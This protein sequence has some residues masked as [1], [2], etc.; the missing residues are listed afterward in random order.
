MPTAVAGDIVP[1]LPCAPDIGKT[2][3]DVC[4][5]LGK[6]DIRAAFCVMWRTVGCAFNITHEESAGQK[7][8]EMRLV[9]RRHIKALFPKRIIRRSVEGDN[10]QLIRLFFGRIRLTGQDRERGK[11]KGEFL[12]GVSSP[13][14]LLLPSDWGNPLFAAGIIP[15]ERLCNLKRGSLHGFFRLCFTAFLITHSIRIVAPGWREEMIEKIGQG[16][17][18]GIYSVVSIVTL[19]LLIYAFGASRAVTSVLYSPP[20]WLTHIMLLLMLVSIILL[21]VSIFPAGRL[22]VWTKHPMLASVKVWALAHLLANGEANS[23]LLFSGFLVWAVIARISAKRQNAE[24]RSFKSTKWDIA[25]VVSGVAFY[26]I[27]VM[28]LHEILIG[29]SPLAMIAV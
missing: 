3:F 4:R 5:A 16:A 19:G 15:A 11:E 23:V 12:H 21:M 20:V 28:Y 29:V 24:P 18:R 1:G 6:T 9:A 25:A 27:I 17:W 14:C 10:D 26:A 2:G 8:G 13:V 7:I 22:A